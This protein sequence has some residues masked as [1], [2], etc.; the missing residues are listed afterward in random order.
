MLRR[1]GAAPRE[2]VT[3]PL[4]RYPA[5]KADI[6]ALVDV[7]HGSSSG[8]QAEPEMPA[9]DAAADDSKEAVAN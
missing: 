3:D 9:N 5:A 8:N 6:L 2:I 7:K 1:N 4:R